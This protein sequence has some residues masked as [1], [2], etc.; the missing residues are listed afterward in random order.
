MHS[1]RSPRGGTPGHA[2]GG[3]S[4]DSTALPALLRA[5]H[6]LG[7]ALGSAF[8]RHASA[9]EGIVWAEALVC[10][11]QRPPQF[12]LRP[13]NDPQFPLQTHTGAHFVIE[14][15]RSNRR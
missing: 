7:L 9:R 6:L 3:R 5:S 2:V 12:P 13:Y 1:S 10:A 8:G 4:L 14:G 15:S 11:R